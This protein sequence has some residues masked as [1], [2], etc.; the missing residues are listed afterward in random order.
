[1][2]SMVIFERKVNEEYIDNTLLSSNITSQYNYDGCRKNVEKLLDEYARLNFKYINIKPPKI[3]SNYE[4]RYESY[5]PRK[6]DP[7]GNSVELKFDTELEVKQFYS[8]ISDLVDLM[9]N[10]EF[11]FFTEILLGHKS[12]DYIC[13]KMG[14]SRTGLVPIKTSCV[15][16]MAMA[17][18]IEVFS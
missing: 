13:E 14:I 18:K 8:Q 2:D 11:K 1:M 15:V 4:F 3:T 12:E 5:V 9:S 10:D 7:V 16:K 17:F 6:A